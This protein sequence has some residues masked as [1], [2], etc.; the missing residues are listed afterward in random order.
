MEKFAPPKETQQYYKIFILQDVDGICEG[1]LACLQAW[2]VFIH[3]ACA[4]YK[5]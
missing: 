5:L 1:F 3:L 2:A 4:P